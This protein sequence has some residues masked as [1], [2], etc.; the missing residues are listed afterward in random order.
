VFAGQ[1]APFG[2]SRTLSPDDMTVEATAGGASIRAGSRELIRSVEDA[3]VAVWDRHGRFVRAV[4]LTADGGVPASPGTLA[5]HEFTG[6]HEWTAL[7][8]RPLD[9]TAV[10][11]SGHLV[12]RPGSSRTT[13][14]MYAGRAAALA[15]SLFDADDKS[16]LRVDDLIGVDR[17]AAALHRDGWDANLSLM[18]AAHVYRIELAM[19]GDPVHLAFGGHPDVLMACA[20]SGTN[21]PVPPAVFGLD[22]GPLEMIDAR[23]ERL[24]IARDAEQFFIGAGWSPV[25]AEPVGGFRMTA[26]PEAELLIPR[27]VDAP[28]LVDLQLRPARDA[29]YVELLVN[30]HTV[31]TSRVAGAWER[32]RWSV[33]PHL[34][35]LGMNSVVLRAAAPVLIADALVQ[36]VAE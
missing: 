23:T 11:S 20:V 30:G 6:F 35:R 21:A 22:P 15:P 29:A 17:V 32:Y 34:A 2:Q 10:A 4:A 8:G 5:L 25:D 27:E 3:V 33:P 19:T 7:T 28:F 24:H 26:S 1:G 36:R 16:S 31:G 12:I 18:G 14:V 13:L 9:I